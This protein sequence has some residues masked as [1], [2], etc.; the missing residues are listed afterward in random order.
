MIIYI[1]IY[2]YI[3]IYTQCRPRHMASSPGRVTHAYSLQSSPPPF[4]PSSPPCLHSVQEPAARA[5]SHIRPPC[6]L[7]RIRAV[8]QRTVEI[9]P[10]LT[11]PFCLRASKTSPHSSQCAARRLSP[12]TTLPLRHKLTRI[13]QLL[14]LIITRVTFQPILPS[15]PHL[16]NLL[17][18]PSAHRCPYFPRERR[19]VWGGQRDRA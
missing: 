19:C 4:L 1:Y 15:H 7:S 18:I 14:T 10:L 12:H 16:L 9:P 5:A 8:R 2:I 11:H 13:P 6:R 17:T 3:C